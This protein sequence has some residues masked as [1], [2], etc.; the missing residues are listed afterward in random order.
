MT[1]A[2]TKIDPHGPYA[3]EIVEVRHRL[4]DRDMLFVSAYL[5]DPD[6]ERAAIAAGLP[7]KKG[8][9]YSNRRYVSRA[10][11]LCQAER[12]DRLSIRPDKTIRELAKIGFANMGDYLK[13]SPDGDPIPN[14]EA[15]DRDRAAA[16]SE[17]VVE[18]YVDGRGEDA[19]QVKRVKFKLH[20]KQAALVTLAR[21][22]GMLLDRTRVE[23]D[24]DIRIKNMTTD[25]RLQMLHDLLA[26][27][28][29]YLT[30]EELQVIEHDEE[31]VP[32]NG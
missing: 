16:L 32:T 30:K 31:E 24:I 1:N 13:F 9:E 11:D 10:I 25:E 23:G 28:E 3:A 4:T 17:V 26:P 7:A 15:I 8:K 27:M 19:R 18:D 22:Q 29:K 21:V 12:A 2:L 6:P 5:D 14:L 20:D